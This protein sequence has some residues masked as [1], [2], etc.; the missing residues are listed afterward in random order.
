MF[1]SNTPHSEKPRPPSREPTAQSF[2][3]RRL[4]WILRLCDRRRASRVKEG[5][6]GPAVAVAAAAGAR[7]RIERERKM[8]TETGMRARASL[9]DGT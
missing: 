2:W 9:G 7:R 1:L 6:Q 5:V 8:S 3:T 4:R